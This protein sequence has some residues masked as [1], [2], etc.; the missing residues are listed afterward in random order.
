MGQDPA[1]IRKEIEQTREHMGETVDALGYK[2]DV[3]ARAK[4]SVSEKV[5]S[6]KSR[7]TG[8]GSQISDGTPDAGEVKQGAKQAVGVV[9]ENPLGLAIGAAAVGFLAGMLVP[10]TKIEDERIGPMADQVKEQAKQTGEAALQSGKEIAQE[11]AETATQKAQEAVAEAKETA[12]DS[13][14]T[15]AQDMTESA[16]ESAKHV[17]AS[18]QGT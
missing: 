8:V 16:K 6:L 1:V 14:Q 18:P 9:Q 10:S 3:P 17:V 5:D 13:A 12:Q 4:D 15:H 7:I 2:A 11:T